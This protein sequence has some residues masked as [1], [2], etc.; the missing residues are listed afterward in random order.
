MGLTPKPDVEDSNMTIQQRGFLTIM[1]D[2]LDG[3]ARSLGCLVIVAAVLCLAVGRPGVM[4]L[5][6]AAAAVAETTSP[7]F[8]G[9]SSLECRTLL[10]FYLVIFLA[11]CG[12][13][14][15]FERRGRVWS[16]VRRSAT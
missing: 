6:S 4:A 11:Y 10:A 2:K 9:S 14:W 5:K 16:L 13:I 12:V 8:D 7:P 3:A 15:A 1:R